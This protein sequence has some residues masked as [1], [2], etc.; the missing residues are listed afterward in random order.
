MTVL[1]FL[2]ADEAVY[3]LTDTVVSHPDD[4]SPVTFTTKVHCLP[5]LQAL[6]CGT[7]HVQSI[8]EW[9]VTVN[10]G[11]LARDV[12]HLD[13]FA[14]AELRKLFARHTSGGIR[15]RDITTT[16]YHFGF[17]AQAGHFAGFAYRSTDGF[18]SERLQEG[19]GFKPAPDWPLDGAEIKKLP[20]DFIA[21]AKKQKTQ[22]EASALAKRVGVGGHLVFY[23]MQRIPGLHGAF[24]VQTSA[25]ICHTFPDFEAMYVSA[26]AKVEAG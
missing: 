17:D 3:V 19:F 14:P 9:V 22:D 6:I 2:L 20:D 24:T 4:L 8:I 11:I 10:M 5:H 18:R 15:D 16:L 13:Q 25:A 23:A 26:A 21:I 1:N 12:V 7:G